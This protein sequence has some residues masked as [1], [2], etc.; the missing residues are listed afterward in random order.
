MFWLCNVTYLT[1]LPNNQLE[2]IMM[3]IIDGKQT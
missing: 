2:V 3:T 1:K